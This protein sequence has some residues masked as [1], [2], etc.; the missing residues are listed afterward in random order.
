MSERPVA[1][2]LLARGIAFAWR[3]TRSMMIDAALLLP[4]LRCVRDTYD[5]PLPI[6]METWFLQRV[7]GMNRRIPWPVHYRSTVNLPQNVRLGAYSFPGVQPGCY[8][9]AMGTL[10]IGDYCFF[11]PNVGILAGNHDPYNLSQYIHSEV[12]IGS[13]CWVGMGAI[14]LPGVVLGDFTTV[15]A[16]AVVTKSFE[17]GYCVIAGNPAVVVKRLDPAKCT[18]YRIEPEYVG[19]TRRRA[20]PREAPLAV[21]AEKAGVRRR[22]RPPFAGA[23]DKSSPVRSRTG[24]RPSRGG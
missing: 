7:L 12:R 18:R 21:S 16:G 6:L 5:K 22:S 20:P 8:I 13:Y 17:E 10:S 2:G 24:E 15:G 4:F 9:Q 11:G 1:K 19:Y 23:A 3:S 14:I